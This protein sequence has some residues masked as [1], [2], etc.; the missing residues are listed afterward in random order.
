MVNG[1]RRGGK[2]HPGSCHTLH[3]LGAVELFRSARGDGEVIPG[4]AAAGLDVLGEEHDLPDVVGVVGDLAGDGEDDGVGLPADVDGLFE[5]AVAQDV[6]GGEDGGPAP[7]PQ[8]D[9]PVA[10]DDLFGELIV[11]V[12]RGPFAVAAEE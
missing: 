12:T 3:T 10:G 6:E 8:G 5:V 4:L 2:L 11:A 1:A 7:V 9:D